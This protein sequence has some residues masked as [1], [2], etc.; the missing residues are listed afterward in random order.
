MKIPLGAPP[1]RLSKLLPVIRPALK[2][3]VELKLKASYKGIAAV[4]YVLWLG[5]VTMAVAHY[6]IFFGEQWRLLKPLFGIVIYL[7]ALLSARKC[8]SAT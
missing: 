5:V 4:Y 6:P 8:C 7:T 1:C 2:Y 3:T